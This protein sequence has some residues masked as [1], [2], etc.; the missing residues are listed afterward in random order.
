MVINVSDSGGT[1][2]M[3][4]RAINSHLYA[5]GLALAYRNGV[6]VYDP[7]YSLAQDP[8]FWE[9]V[10][11]DPIVKHAMDARLH[12]AAGRDW[13]VSP[14]SRNPQ[15]DDERAATVLEQILEEIQDFTQGRFNL[16]KGVFQG[17]SWAYIE[18]ERRM[19]EIDGKMQLW[20][21][22]TRLR[23][24]DKRHMRLAPTWDSNAAPGNRIGAHYEILDLENLNWKPLHNHAPLIHF[25]YDDEEG[26]MNHGRGISEAIYFYHYAKGVVLTEGLEG[27]E[28]WARGMVVA[29][30]DNAA[31]GA[32]SNKQTADNYLKELEKQRHGGIMVIDS[33]DELEVQWPESSG[34]DMVFQWLQYLDSGIVTV[35]LGQVI[36][37][38][39]GALIAEAL[40]RAITEGTSSETLL[41]YD[42]TTLYQTLT[43]D[44]V[45]HIWYWNQPNLSELGLG[46]ARRPTLRAAAI[47]DS[48]PKEAIDIVATA[49][50]TGIPL[51]RKEVYDR[52]GFTPP[53]TEDDVIE[54]I[55]DPGATQMGDPMTD[56][57]MEKDAIGNAPGPVKG[58]SPPPSRP[59]DT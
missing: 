1:N 23:H 56:P 24:I 34:N 52:I 19:I 42:R 9:K 22:P 5:H 28:K 39:G 37:Q 41:G 46:K 12:S 58:A 25:R 10:Q 3:F 15:P 35:I 38:S 29:K 48:N 32:L 13:Q 2:F 8:E 57:A 36:P 53:G 43:R 6:E 14:G 59:S 30:L 44:L 21:I 33:K 51:L 26:R 49:L 47:D 50:S 16:A 20:W 45:G 55:L 27:L 40:T 11:R 4:S 54:G 18:S 31:A 17:E 7:D